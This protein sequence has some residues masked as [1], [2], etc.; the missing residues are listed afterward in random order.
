MIVEFDPDKDA[1][2]V[3]DHGI[4]L[5][6]AAD[7]IPL[8]TIADDRFDYGE[9]RFRTY[10][11]IDGRAYCLVFTM[12]GENIRAISLRRAHFQEIKRHVP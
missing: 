3:A 2:N 1:S 7:M 9:E 8:A 11:Q 6:R 5:A 4:S 10:G 12:R